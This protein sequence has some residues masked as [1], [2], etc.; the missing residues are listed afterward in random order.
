MDLSDIFIVLFY[1]Y[2]FEFVLFSFLFFE[3][4]KGNLSYIGEKAIFIY[5]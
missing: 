3:V 2:R 4:W 1:I 5:K